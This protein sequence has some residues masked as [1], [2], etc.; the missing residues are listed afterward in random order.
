MY[1]CF[2]T[3]SQPVVQTEAAAAAVEQ[4]MRLWASRVVGTGRFCV[5]GVCVCD[6]CRDAAWRDAA[7][8]DAAC[9]GRM[10]PCLTAT[11]HDS[12]VS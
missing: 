4:P 8:R 9:R 6:V 11:A 2:D 5:W 12:E 1:V 10:P 7:W 3:C